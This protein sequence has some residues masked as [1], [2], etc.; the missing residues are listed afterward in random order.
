MNTNQIARA[1]ESLKAKTIGVYA[2]DRIPNVV[3][4]SAAIVCNTDDHTRPGSHWVAIY[5][6]KHRLGTY[7]DSYGFPPVSR[8]HHYRLRTNCKNFRWNV[9]T[10]QNI[11]SICCGQYTTMV[12]YHMCR[13]IGL[14]TFCRLFTDDTRKNDA[15]VIIIKKFLIKIS[16]ENVTKYS[17]FQAKALM[18]KVYVINRVFLD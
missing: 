1:L 8:H 6:D 16:I 7:F 18:A 3:M 9:K 12:L 2:D 17:L 15:L 11:D 13:G 5:I 14:D 4:T 10:L